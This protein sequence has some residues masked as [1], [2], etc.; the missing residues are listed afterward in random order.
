MKRGSEEVRGKDENEDNYN[1]EWDS[2]D[3]L[4]DDN[5]DESNY[6]NDDDVESWGT[7]FTY[8][9]NNEE[10]PNSDNSPSAS[11]FDEVEKTEREHEQLIEKQKYLIIEIKFMVLITLIIFIKLIIKLI[12]KLIINIFIY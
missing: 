11:M 1:G 6:Q 3:H 7:I 8:E 10:K 9:G 2:D 5:D 4:S 12:K